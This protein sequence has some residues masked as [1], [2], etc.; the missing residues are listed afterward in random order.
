MS[1]PQTCPRLLESH[2]HDLLFYHSLQDSFVAKT[3]P[4][5]A[6]RFSRNFRNIICGNME[7]CSTGF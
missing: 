5:P 6:S 4:V 1:N 7:A 2:H 3:E